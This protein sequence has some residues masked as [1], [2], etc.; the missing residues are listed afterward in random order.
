MYPEISRKILCAA[1][2]VLSPWLFVACHR[3]AVPE[4]QPAAAAEQQ[5]TTAANSSAAVGTSGTA[6]PN[7]QDSAPATPAPA[8][9]ST[10]TAPSGT[11][12][13]SDSPNATMERDPDAIKALEDMGRYLRTLN[14]FQ[15]RTQT[16]RDEVLADGQNIEFGAIVDMIVAR[17]NR[18]RAE[19]TSDKQ[20]RLYFDDGKTFSVWARR[21]NYYATVPA[22]ATL[23]EL[24]DTLADRYNIELPV[25]DLFYWGD[26]R[27][28][29]QIRGAMDIGPSQIDG[30]T[31]EH[32]AFRQDG[33]D[34]QVWIQQGDYPLPRKLVIT[35]MT[36][37]ARPKFTSVM[38]WNLAPSF[39]DA[40]FT[41]VPPKDAR[42]IML[43][44]APAARDSQ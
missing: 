40:A 3:Q 28:T 29:E 4:L 2:A 44:Q 6:T 24:A 27:N 1:A 15:I 9:P 18:L 13:P 5:D 22:P 12:A 39:N 10:S 35:T 38:T 11:T 21:M 14:A 26:T 43:I 36:D 19:V 25:A 37:P 33:A 41:F 30:V 42:R 32:Y 16:T 34:W 23:R 20:Q 7:P 31:C 8:A 17:P